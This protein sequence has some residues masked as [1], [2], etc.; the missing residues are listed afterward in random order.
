MYWSPASPVFPVPHFRELGPESLRV[1]GMGLQLCGLQVGYWHH[2]PVVRSRV[3]ASFF[4][5]SCFAT[6]GGIMIRVAQ[7]K[8]GRLDIHRLSEV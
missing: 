1:P 5:D 8:R 3:M 2:E 7:Q 6:G 4:S